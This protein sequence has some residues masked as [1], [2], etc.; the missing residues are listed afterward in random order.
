MSTKSIISRHEKLGKQVVKNLKDRHFEA[1]YCNSCEEALTLALSLI[2]ESDI[3]A[4]GG[5][6][7]TAKIGLI[8]V[9]QENFQTINR[10]IATSP[11]EKMHLMRRSLL[12]DTYITG[13]NAISEDG[14]LV[15]I[16]GI[17]NRVA[18]M[19]FGPKNVIIVAGMNK[20]VK[21]IEDAVSRARTY[22]APVNA[23]RF[24]DLSTPCLKTGSCANCKSK[25]SICS[26]ISITRLCK[27]AGRIKVIL[28]G[29]NLGY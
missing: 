12:A 10:D 13:T 14:Q 2:P 4:W 26:F 1:F 15:N 23:Q 11:A 25:D 29:E 17:G 18:A 22:A 5:S 19:T 8:E 7:T 28:I 21:T 20:V 27:P 24:P 6:A 3:V 9:V 16:D